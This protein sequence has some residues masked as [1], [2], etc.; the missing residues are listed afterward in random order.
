[1]IIAML[2]AA[3]PDSDKSPPVTIPAVPTDVKA[4]AKSST[5]I[6]VTWKLV[7]G[8]TSYEVHREIGSSRSWLTTVTRNTHTDTD[9]EHD[10]TYKYYIAAKND[11][12]TSDLSTPDS[13]TTPESELTIP[14]SPTGVTA[15]A[16][17]PTSIRITWNPISNATSYEIYYRES[18]YSGYP[19]NFVDEI[20]GCEFLHTSL[21][22]NTTYYYNIKAKNRVG[23]SDYSSNTSAKTQSGSTTIPV[24]PTGVTISVQSSTSI[25]ITWNPVSTATNYDVYYAVGSSSSGK[26]FAGNISSTTYNHTNLQPDTTYFYFIRA[27]ND[28]GNSDFSSA[29]SAKT[30]PSPATKPANPS[31]IAASAKSSTSILVTWNSVSNATSYDVYYSASSYSSAAVFIDNVTILSYNHNNLQP[32]T[33]YY[34]FIKAKNSAG[35]SGFSSSAS[36]KTPVP[37]ITI[38]AIPTGVSA[39]L[40]PPNSIR[41]TWNT[42]SN[43]TGY[44]VY[45]TIDSSSS[46]PIFVSTVTNPL[47]T[48]SNL[49]SD[50]TYFYFIKAK[51]SAGY[52]EY[53]SPASAKTQL[54]Q[55]P[56]APTGVTAKAQSSSSI[57]VSWDSVSD[58]ISYD[59]YYTVGSSSTKSLPI[60]VTNTS[61]THSSLQ[62]ETIYNYFIK[63]KNSAGDSDDFSSAASA[64]TQAPPVTKPAAPTGVKASYVSSTNR[65]TV[66]WDA[67]SGATS[68]SVYYTT[69]V[70]TTKKVASS[71]ITR[72]TSYSHNVS[73]INANLFFDVINDSHGEN[74]TNN[75]TDDAN[76]RIISPTI[77]VYY[78][79]TAKNSAGVESDFS[80]SSPIVNIPRGSM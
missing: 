16:V 25:R 19:F 43:A 61:Y 66:S 1:M 8:A 37:E 48:H 73:S 22:P 5:S 32:N 6:T 70:G 31:G 53:S 34:Y 23:L 4:E 72:G 12:G 57:I 3:C 56:S 80:A 54:I 26:T 9:L 58:A 40:Q 69:G 75:I 68:Y 29:V 27:K 60:N 59:V 50:T 71:S 63:A 10:T 77:T 24:I 2:L 33:T 30:Q 64:T 7:S 49:Q 47:Y 41:I 20:T 21:Q 11:A 35:D 17:S 39:S 65:V 55:K 38:P 14:E 28:A 51:N 36:A 76:P 78:Y 45:Y 74:T 18:T 46:S 52:S 13:A 42:V 79:V 62:S 67:V 15:A 44:D